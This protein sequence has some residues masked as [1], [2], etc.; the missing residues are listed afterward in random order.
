MEEQPYSFRQTNQDTVRYEFESVSKKKVV[1]KIVEYTLI[2][3]DLSLYNLALLDAFENSFSDTSISNND[4]MPKVLATVFQTIL[5]F[6][7]ANPSAVIVFEGST[8]SRT[9]LYRIAIA[10]SKYEIEHKFR[11]LGL[12]NGEF[13]DFVNNRDYKA[14][15]LKQ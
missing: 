4:D 1:R 15:L 9:R 14:F 12:I 3:K 8:P 7:E 11:I 10:R 13:E 5:H 2:D 6:F